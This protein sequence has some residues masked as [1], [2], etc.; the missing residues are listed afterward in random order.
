M[1]RRLLM[2]ALALGLASQASAAGNV[3]RAVKVLANGQVK[4]TLSW[5]SDASGSV[6]GNSLT[7]ASGRIVQAQFVPG[8]GGTVP[9]ALY[10]VTLV[11]TNS[12]D[13][14]QAGGADLSA[15]V[16]KVSVFYPPAY[17]DAAL[18]LVVANAG[19]AKT[20]TVTVWVQR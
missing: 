20:G 2:L 18:T 15:T 6:S 17:A 11:D 13:L 9:T 16:S 3:D 4:Y 19:N 5:T 12:V 14:L 7:I 1:K 8:T 10:D